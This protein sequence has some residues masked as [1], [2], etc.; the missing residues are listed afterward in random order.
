MLQARAC[1]TVIP[2]H[3]QDMNFA[4]FKRQLKTLLFRELVL[5]PRRIVT[6]CC[7]APYKYSYLLMYLLTYLLTYLLP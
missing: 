6:V 1:G 3:L 5:Q 4:R 2:P 7:F